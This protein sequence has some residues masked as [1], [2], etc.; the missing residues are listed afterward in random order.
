METGFRTELTEERAAMGAS[1]HP[2]DPFHSTERFELLRT[3]LQ[4][5]KTIMAFIAPRGVG[6]TSW[7]ADA[8]VQVQIRRRFM[9]LGQTLES[10][11]VWDTRRAVQAVREVK[12]MKDIPLWLQGRGSSAANNIYAALFEPEIA[13]LELYQVPTSHEQ[14]PD[15]LNVLRVLD[16]PQAIAMVAER[17][18]I[19]IHNRDDHGWNF[20]TQLKTKLGW[21]DKQFEVFSPFGRN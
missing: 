2:T 15:Y 12:G 6:L 14:G 7:N 1:D 11:R 3:S 16:L 18:T 5:N 13:G 21:N 9:L 10:M 8:R 17:S 4:T 20:P 19:R